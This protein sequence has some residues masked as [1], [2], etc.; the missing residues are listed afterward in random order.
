MNEHNTRRKQCV[1]CGGPW[2]DYKQNG[3]KACPMCR[4][5]VQ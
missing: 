3:Q 2:T 5:G 4:G 1:V